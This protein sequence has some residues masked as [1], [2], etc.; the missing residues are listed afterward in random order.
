VAHQVVAGIALLAERAAILEGRHVLHDLAEAD[1]H[2][3]P[4]GE[5]RDQIV[6][7]HGAAERR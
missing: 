4:V 3:R 5:H 2:G 7:Q 6:A 1:L